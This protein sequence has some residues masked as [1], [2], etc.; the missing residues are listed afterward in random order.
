[1]LDSAIITAAA[2]EYDLYWAFARNMGLWKKHHRH[3]I[4]QSASCN[5][6]FPEQFKVSRTKC[7]FCFDECGLQD[8]MV[9]KLSVTTCST[10]IHAR[11]RKAA[12]RITQATGRLCSPQPKFR[13]IVSGRSCNIALTPSSRQH[14][15]RLARHGADAGLKTS[16]TT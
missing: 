12:V 3:A 15:Q 8:G 11:K 1:M 10:G 16:I 9:R 6:W 14:R 13:L 5:V 2:Q 7:T 4:L